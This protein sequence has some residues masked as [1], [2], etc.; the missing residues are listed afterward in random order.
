MQRERNAAHGSRK[1]SLQ[2]YK[3]PE[4]AVYTRRL[5]QKHYLHLADGPIKKE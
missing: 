4:E 3:H 5:E 1:L 2:V